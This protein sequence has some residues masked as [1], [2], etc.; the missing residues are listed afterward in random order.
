VDEVEYV[1]TTGLSIL[2]A[3]YLSANFLKSD[4]ILK[5]V[6]IRL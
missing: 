6:Y 4:F 5:V 2:C 3:I 1:Y